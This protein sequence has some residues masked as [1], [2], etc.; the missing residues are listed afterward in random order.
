MTDMICRKS[1]SRCLTPGM[2]SPHGGCRD[3]AAANGKELQNL[4]TDNNQLNYA[5]KQSELR[6]LE[7]RAERDQLKAENEA[8]RNP[9]AHTMLELA[10]SYWTAQRKAG[11][12]GAVKWIQN[13]ETGATLIF[14][15]GEYRDVLMAAVA[16][17]AAQPSKEGKL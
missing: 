4:R 8:L 5:L 10:N 3:D 15:R 13:E 6:Y 17:I 7:L 9:D 11:D 16:S 1:M 2:C 12:P 14:T